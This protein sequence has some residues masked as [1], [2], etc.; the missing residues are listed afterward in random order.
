MGRHERKSSRGRCVD[1]GSEYAPS[2]MATHFLVKPD[3]LVPFDPKK[4]NTKLIA[5]HGWQEWMLEHVL[6]LDFF[7]AAK[8]R[9]FGL[10]DAIPLGLDGSS[11]ATVPDQ[12]YIERS[13]RLTIVELKSAEITA[14]PC[15]LAQVLAYGQHYR[16]LPWGCGVAKV[17][18]GSSRNSGGWKLA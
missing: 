7:G 10:D 16:P 9:I 11:T 2:A 15:E 12:L 5:I 8:S 17:W 18:R 1:G 13:G 14:G 4:R 6:V 3:G